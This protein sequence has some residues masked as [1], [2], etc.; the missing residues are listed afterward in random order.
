MTDQLK[1]TDSQIFYALPLRD[2]VIFPQMTLT[3]LVGRKKSLKSIRSAIKS[4]VPI[5]VVAHFPNS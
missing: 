5:F 3:V 4:K 1:I 2:I